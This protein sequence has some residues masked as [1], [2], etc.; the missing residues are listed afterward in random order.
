VV[1]A[2]GDSGFSF[3]RMLGCLDARMLDDD[4]DSTLLYY[5]P[6]AIRY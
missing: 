6:A 5:I 3:P 2:L 4:D 1:C